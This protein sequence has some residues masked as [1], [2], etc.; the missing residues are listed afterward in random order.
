MWLRLARYD[1]SLAI[2]SRCRIAIG[3]ATGVIGIAANRRIAS[4]IICALWICSA[5]SCLD[6]SEAL[7][8]VLRGRLGAGD[9]SERGGDIGITLLGACGFEQSRFGICRLSRGEIPSG[10]VL[11]CFQRDVEL[12]GG[13]AEP[14]GPP[15][16]LCLPLRQLALVFGAL[17]IAPGA[18]ELATRRLEL[19]A[20]LGIGLLEHRQE[21]LGIDL[22]FGFTLYLRGHLLQHIDQGGEALF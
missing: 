11:H 19:G 6:R 3:T 22:I 9:G 13:A 5:L 17:H 2:V 8:Q 4:P 7:R 21:V 1:G 16:R 20:R 12:A 10:S 14:G 18:I 15:S